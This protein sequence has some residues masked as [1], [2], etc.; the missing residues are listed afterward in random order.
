M[1]GSESTAAQTGSLVSYSVP[2]V[3]QQVVAAAGGSVTSILQSFL[4]GFSE[5]LAVGSAGVVYHNAIGG[6]Q[7]G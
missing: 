1:L 3:P 4:A 5:V 6:F 7:A 2:G